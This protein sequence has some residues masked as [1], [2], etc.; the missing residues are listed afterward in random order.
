MNILSHFFRKNGVVLGE[1]CNIYSNILT[2]ESQLINIG[3]NVTISNDVQF[4]THDNSVC[5]ISSEY[6]DTFGKIKI[7]D[8]CFIG[9]R[10]T[11]LPGVTLADNI[12]VG[13]ASVISKSFYETGIVI[14][15][16]PAKKICTIDEYR[17]KV[18]DKLF[19][20]DGLNKMEKKVLLE[21]N[22]KKFIR[23]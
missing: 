10:T 9:A 23:R 13:S 11:I 12:I 17:N 8:N 16:N 21:S 14:A 6:T 19:N 20:V 4:I 5:K 18:N 22:E 3:N 1:N 2:S 7:G 15:G